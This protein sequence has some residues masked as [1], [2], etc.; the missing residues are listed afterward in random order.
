M[1]K[2][3]ECLINFKKKKMILLTKEQQES[4]E[5]VKICYICKEK[6]KNKYVKDK[7]YC[8]FRNRCHYTAEYRGA[9]YSICNLKYSAP[10]KSYSFL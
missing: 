5:N 3:C 7:K 8:K 4:F 2:F 10:K 1:K 9:A 6:L